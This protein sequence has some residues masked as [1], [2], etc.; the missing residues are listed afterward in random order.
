MIIANTSP[1]AGL[2]EAPSR[3]RVL[4][5]VR[6]GNGLSRQACLGAVCPRAGARVRETPDVV[7]DVLTFADVRD[8]AKAA[9]NVTVTLSAFGPYFKLLC[10]YGG[11]PGK[12]V[13]PVLLGETEG[14][15]VAP[16]RI[17]HVDSMRIYNSK[18]KRLERDGNET[19][20]LG[21]MGLGTLQPAQSG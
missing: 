13:A 14:F 10:H 2:R 17:L 16:L 1:R 15:I 21:M 6:V 9:L 12:G 7:P 4:H 3:A 20:Q 11:Q 19:G 5:D 8:G 18:M